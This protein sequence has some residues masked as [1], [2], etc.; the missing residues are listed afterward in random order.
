MTNIKQ[1]G[2]ALVSVCLTSLLAQS[3]FAVDYKLQLDYE[4]IDQKYL[5]EKTSDSTST[6]SYLGLVFENI[7]RTQRVSLYLYPNRQIADFLVKRKYGKILESIFQLN[8]DSASE[9]RNKTNASLRVNIGRRDIFSLK[10]AKGHALNTFRRGGN[11]LILEATKQ[12]IHVVRNNT[13]KTIELGYAS[14][15]FNFAI[16]VE[17]GANADSAFG[18]ANY[19][20]DELASIVLSGIDPDILEYGDLFREWDATAAEWAA[21]ADAISGIYS[22][23]LASA[24]TA[25]QNA[26]TASQDSIS[27]SQWYSSFNELAEYHSQTSLATDFTQTAS[28]ASSA[29]ISYNSFETTRNDATAEVARINSLLADGI[30]VEDYNASGD[31]SLFFAVNDPAGTIPTTMTFETTP[32]GGVDTPFAITF[33]AV[34]SL[35]SDF[36]NRYNNLS[37]SLFLSLSDASFDALLDAVGGQKSPNWSGSFFRNL[38]ED[39][40][41]ISTFEGSHII[42]DITGN[43][44]RKFYKK[45]VR[46]F[47]TN[48]SDYIIV[49]ETIT[50]C[51]CTKLQVVKDLNGAYNTIKNT[52]TSDTAIYYQ[53]AADVSDGARSYYSDTNSTK[54]L[55]QQALPSLSGNSFT[56]TIESSSDLESLFANSHYNP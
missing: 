19:E 7:P 40:N 22:T 43:T 24:N 3:I 33:A 44:A 10:L 48:V 52:P 13:A 38:I 34:S 54:L 36:Y 21:S 49:I 11:N 25:T 6:E 8:Y 1:I 35:N 41:N 39:F 50:G 42:A 16:I 53:A 56:P 18:G 30:T 51:T 5:T 9:D 2:L 32:P 14:G 28:N 23:A 29:L 4:T 31:I 45:Y 20:S 55:I 17:N 27:F 37:P 47:E 26:N 15:G 12:E 46:N